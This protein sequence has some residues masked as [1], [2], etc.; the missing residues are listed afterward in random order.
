M[1]GDEADENE[2]PRDRF[3]TVYGR[4]P[5]LEAL[6][7]PDLTCNKVLIADRARGDSVSEIL[8]AATARNVRVERVSERRVTAIARNSRQHQ[9][10]VADVV[11]PAMR[12][13]ARFLD[14]RT[15]GRQYATAVLVLDSVHNPANVGMIIRSALAAGIDG[16]VVPDVGTASLGPLVIKASAGTAFHAPIL[17]VDDAASACTMLAE[18]RFTLVGLDPA[19]PDSLFD[20]ELPERVAVVLGNE[21]DGLTPE[22]AALLHQSVSIPLASPVE[23]L[24]VACAATLVAYAVGNLRRN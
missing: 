18:D 21:T 11:A 3:I 9:G 2:N 24:N 20:T 13:L 23:S 14:E 4:K 17:T 7:A 19:G 6:A 12:T 5:V 10:V 1:S 22:V 16:I 15:G 8:T